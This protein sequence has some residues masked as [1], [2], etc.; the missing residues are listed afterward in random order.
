LT[1]HY[2]KKNSVSFLGFLIR[3]K[4]RNFCLLSQQVATFDVKW[5]FTT[6]LMMLHGP[7]HAALKLTMP[8]FSFVVKPFLYQFSNNITKHTAKSKIKKYEFLIYQPRKSHFCL[9]SL[10]VPNFS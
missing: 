8:S 1:L 10:S 9:I 4:F 5:A 2:H 6:Q 3:S 7:Y